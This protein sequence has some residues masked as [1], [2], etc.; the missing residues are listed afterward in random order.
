MGGIGGVAGIRSGREWEGRRRRGGGEGGGGPMV[1]GALIVV[2]AFIAPRR[3]EG[4]PRWEDGFMGASAEATCLVPDAVA[5][6]AAAVARRRGIGIQGVDRVRWGRHLVDEGAQHQRRRIHL[7]G[8]D[9]QA[10]GKVHAIAQGAEAVDIAVLA[11]RVRAV[12]TVV[13]GAKPTAGGKIFPGGRGLG[14]VKANAL[15]IWAPPDEAIG[16]GGLVEGAHPVLQDHGHGLRHIALAVQDGQD[17][18]RPVGGSRRLGGRGRARGRRA[19]GAA[20]LAG[21]RVDAFEE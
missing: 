17:V 13:N 2:A 3:G 16:A 15:V 5:G 10:E 4:P 20:G 21:R 12:E 9:R 8:L 18:A 6:R 1:G 7:P 19:V 14:V 11:G